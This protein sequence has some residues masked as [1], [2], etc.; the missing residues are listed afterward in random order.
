MKQ[1]NITKKSRVINLETKYLYHLTS[2]ESD[3]NTQDFRSVLLAAL[4]ELKIEDFDLI[5][6][7]FVE[8]RHF[9]QIAE[10]LTKQESAVKMKIYRIL[11]KLKVLLQKK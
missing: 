5:E 10:I 8:N 4:R 2:E 9:K 1:L 7:R 6:M 3:K 11:P